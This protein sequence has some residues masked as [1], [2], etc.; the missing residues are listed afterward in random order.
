MVL[1]LL[2]VVYIHT[3][4]TSRVIIPGKKLT[5]CQERNAFV[6][7]IPGNAG[8]L[9]V[10]DGLVVHEELIPVVAVRK[11]HDNEPTAIHATL[12]GMGSWVP[13]IK[14]ANEENRLCRRGDT[15]EIYRLGCVSCGIRIGSAL[16]KHKNLREDG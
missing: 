6:A 16:I 10:K 3:Y 12:H 4:R 14:I 8:A 15:I 13:V 11:L 5:Y 1:S 2:T 7:H 9:R